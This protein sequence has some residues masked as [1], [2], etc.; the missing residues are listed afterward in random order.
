M[1]NGTITKSIKAAVLSIE[2]AH[3]K[4]NSMPGALLR[5]LA[6]LIS[7]A[8]KDPAIN[9]IILKSSGDSVFCAGASFDEL[10]SVNNQTEAEKF[11][12][13]FAQ[14]ILAMRRCSKPIIGR[15]Q[16]KAIGGGVGLI[17]ACDYVIASANASVRLSEL[18]LGFGPFIIGPV[19]A[20]KIGNPAFQAMTL[21]TEWRDSSWCLANGLYSLLAKDNSEL[22][23]LVEKISTNLSLANAA[24]L[25]ELK[26]VFWSDLPNFE[27]LLKERTKI[28]AK[29][30]LSEFVRN[31]VL[32]VKAS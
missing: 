32:S 20:R 6:E 11:F 19:V 25:L 17:A 8:G 1:S 21:D 12:G 27:A 14:V 13:G 5:Q 29:L 2:F 15:V 22:D 23:S 31:K 3:P 28:T 24:A 4:G 9:S 26:E 18:S 30:V 16:G 7:E 10:L